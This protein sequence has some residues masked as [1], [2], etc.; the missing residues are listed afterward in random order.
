MPDLQ[1][2]EAIENRLEAEIASLLRRAKQ[3]TIRG[4]GG[5]RDLT[6]L[7]TGI[8]TQLLT[9]EDTA[10]QSATNF[11]RMVHGEQ[12]EL[13]RPVIPEEESEDR[14]LEL[15]L[16][17]LL[18]GGARILINRWMQANA[19]SVARQ[20][21]ETTVASS[22]LA[23]ERGRRA[24]QAAR[25]LNPRLTREE[26]AGIFNRAWRHG[27]D[28]SFSPARAGRIGRTEVTKTVSAGE[29]IANEMLRREVGKQLTRIWFRSAR[30]KRCATGICPELDGRP[31]HEWIHLFPAG[32][33]AHPEC[34]CFVEYE[35]RS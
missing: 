13:I 10:L 6:P 28:T 31:E 20:V 11:A 7:F 32:P 4:Y 5:E 25:L 1:N 33:P 9:L 15:L 12:Q 34:L 27:I 26:A 2:R 18:G 19:E 24:V 22:S 35:L 17:L 8:Q 16:L 3:R 21:V 30:E 29:T 23:A 14:R